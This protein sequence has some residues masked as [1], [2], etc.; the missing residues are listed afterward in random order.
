MSLSHKIRARSRQPQAKTACLWTHFVL[1]GD[2]G[3]LHPES[4]LATSK[5]CVTSCRPF[6]DGCRPSE[7]SRVSLENGIGG[8]SSLHSKRALPW[9]QRTGGQF[10]KKTG[11][12]T[13][14]SE[15][16]TP[17]SAGRETTLKIRNAVRGTRDTASPVKSPTTK[18]LTTR[19]FTRR[20]MHKIAAI[21]RTGT[22]AKRSR[23]DSRADQFLTP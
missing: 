1:V 2:V 15:N 8:P 6:H 10:P 11:L 12:S 17:G 18:A 3:S 9:S 23:Y 5:K 13:S 21:V 4:F 20:S 16:P 14:Q 22:R 19:K 7:N